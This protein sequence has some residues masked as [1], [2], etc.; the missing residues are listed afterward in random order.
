MRVHRKVR[1]RGARAGALALVA[2]LIALPWRTEAQGTLSA[3]ETDVDQIARGARPSVVTVFS[4]TTV[5]QPSRRGAPAR[6]RRHTRIGS[7]VAVEESWII[8]TATVAYG[9]EHI[10]VRSTNGLQADAELVGCDPI[11]NLAVLRVRTIRLPRLPLAARDLP[12]AG[13][14]VMTIGTSPYQAEVTQ[15][16]GTVAYLHHEPRLP[17][18]QLTNL[19]YPGYSGGAAL[20]ARGQ[21]IGIIQGELGPS[22]PGDPGYDLYRATGAGFVLP[23]EWVRPAYESLR[24]EG[25]VR[26]GFLGVTTRAATVESDTKESIPIGALVESAQAQGPAARGGLLRGDLI[27]GFDRERVE[28]PQQLARWVAATAPGT[29]VELVWVRDEIEQ[30]SRIVLSESA[31]LEPQWA[32]LPGTSP[33]EP[34]NTSKISDL[35]RQIQRLNRELERLKGQPANPHP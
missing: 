25:R 35:E 13:E 18:L 2:G 33:A 26:H 6:Q 21:L 19:V 30:R 31:D 22:K 32:V 17:L 20:N 5:T 7:G 4:Q 1:L 23:I 3:L 28:N 34:P 14:W 16:V 15:S 24:S 12:A 27:V 29:A 9:A 11:F 8:T 10:F